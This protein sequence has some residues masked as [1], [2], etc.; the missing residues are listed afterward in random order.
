MVLLARRRTRWTALV[1][2]AAVAATVL[3]VAPRVGAD[4]QVL[5]VP[6]GYPTIQAAVTAARPGD[7]VLVAPGVYHES[8]VVPEDKPGLT[9]RGL[10]RND[11]V[12][13]G[14][15]ARGNAITVYAND[16][17]L[18]N[19]TAHSYTGNGFYWRGVDGYT[20][21]YLTTYRVKMYGI[22]AFD[23]VN[24][25]FE[26]S[27][28]SGSAD[29]SFY[30][31]QCRPCN[32]VID[33][34]IAEHSALGYSG[35]NAGGDLVLRNSVWRLNAAGIVPNSLDS[36]RDPPQRGG[37]LITGNTIVNNGNPNV[38]GSGIAGAI[39]GHGV[40]I[41]GGWDNVIEDNVIQGN[42]KYGVVLFPM[43]DSNV[44]LPENN[45]V[46]NNVM[47]YNELADLALAAGSGQ[48][49]C[50]EGN[51]FQRS[52]PALIEEGWPCSGDRL[53]MVPVAGDPVVAAVL[54]RDLAE[55]V[56]EIRQR[57]DYATTPVPPRQPT[58]PDPDPEAW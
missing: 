34:V 16:V 40:A 27:Y 54:V 43:P 42:A 26:K 6:D 12:L 58:M 32:A 20:G 7:L 51:T 45:T 37:T 55:T 47:G 29:A 9:I 38:P 13:D 4:P 8:V 39:M 28:A 57:P 48:G 10:D 31:G 23:S 1:A 17:T 30:I 11:V 3:L 33:D 25:L 14:E 46:R 18:E 44:Y 50:F 5:R 49:N 53:N 15:H 22:Y 41:A 19:M 35:T 52:A 56:G 24:G 2:V 21:R 36:Q